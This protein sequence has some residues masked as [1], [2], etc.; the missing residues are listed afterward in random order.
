[1]AQVT[2]NSERNETYYNQDIIIINVFQNAP[3]GYEIW[4]CACRTMLSCSLN[5]TFVQLTFLPSKKKPFQRLKVLT[6]ENGFKLFFP[7]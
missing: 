5:Q 1:M 3:S 7:I 6:H 2:Q 4:G